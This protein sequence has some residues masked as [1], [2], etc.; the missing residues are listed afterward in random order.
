MKKPD[1]INTITLE[2]VKRSD[3]GCSQCLFNSLECKNYDKFSPKW[4]EVFKQPTCNH[5]AY[6][7]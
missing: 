3:Y 1:N 5:Y 4:S 2:D 6:C 7:D